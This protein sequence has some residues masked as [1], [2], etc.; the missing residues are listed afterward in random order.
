MTAELRVGFGEVAHRA[1]QPLRDRRAGSLGGPGDPPCATAVPD[2]G[3]EVIHQCVEL[4]LGTLGAGEV[5]VVLGVV[6]VL[7]QFA[8]AGLVARRAA[9]S[10]TSPV[11]ASSAPAPVRSRQ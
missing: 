10:I 3:G 6:D 4:G 9:A 5:V 1:A 11:E 2:G 7:L 8:N